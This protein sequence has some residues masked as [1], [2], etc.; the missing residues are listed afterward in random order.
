MAS[1]ARRAQPLRQGEAVPRVWRGSDRI[2]E[3]LN[4]LCERAARCGLKVFLYWQEPMGMRDDHPSGRRTAG[5]RL[6]LALQAD[7]PPLHQ[8][9]RGRSI[10]A[11]ERA[12]S[13]RRCPAWRRP[14]DPPRRSSEP[15]LLAPAPRRPEGAGEAGCRREALPRCALLPAAGD[16]RADP[17]PGARRCE[18]GQPER[19]GDRLELELE[20]LEPDPQRGVLSACRPM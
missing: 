2:L 1:G 20:P 6:Q 11:K 3:R 16:H 12:T 9:A 13:L 5:A 19:R 18:S 10:C 17:H 8:H 4:R 15:L 7:G 14:A